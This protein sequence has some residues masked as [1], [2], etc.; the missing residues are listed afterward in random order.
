MFSE[1]EKTMNNC[2]FFL[3]L[4]S[5]RKHAALFRFVGQPKNFGRDKTFDV[6]QTTLFCLE[7]TSLKAKNDYIF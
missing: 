5:I 3:D 4:A 6:R 2:I 1:N 7:K